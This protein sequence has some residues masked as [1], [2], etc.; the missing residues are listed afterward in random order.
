[1]DKCIHLSIDSITD[2]NEVVNHP[3]EF[4]N[5]LDLPGLPLHNLQLKVGSAKIML[6]NLN[7]PELFNGTRVAVK[8]NYEQFY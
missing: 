2:P 8:K 4:L 3:N 5:L 7:Q 6:R 1:M